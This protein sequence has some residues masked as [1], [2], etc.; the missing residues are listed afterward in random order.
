MLNIWA[1]GL[2]L[3]VKNVVQM[4]QFYVLVCNPVH[5]ER[6]RLDLFDV[7]LVLQHHMLGIKAVLNVELSCL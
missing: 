7:H 6:K 4:K 1:D 5:M 3:V 2:G